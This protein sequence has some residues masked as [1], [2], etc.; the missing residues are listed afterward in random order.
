M[1]ERKITLTMLCE[2]CGSA[3][4][5]DSGHAVNIMD[6]CDDDDLY[7]MAEKKGWSYSLNLWGWLCP[8][9]N[10]KGKKGEK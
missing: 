3:F 5:D 9:C 10:G 2:E 7:E 1:I 4:I 6:Y 8:Y